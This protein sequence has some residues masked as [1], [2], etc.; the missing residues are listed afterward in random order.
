MNYRLAW[1]CAVFV[2]LAVGFYPRHISSSSN[3]VV[4]AVASQELNQENTDKELSDHKVYIVHPRMV[5]IESIES[6]EISDF[7]TIK[8]ADGKEVDV[9]L[10]SF[11]EENKRAL[12]LTA[13]ELVVDPKKEIPLWAKRES[14]RA[15]NDMVDVVI[16]LFEITSKE[17]KQKDLKFNNRDVIE[18][19]ADI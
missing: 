3:K 1:L 4:L 19:R 12:F 7:S 18:I 10:Y 11:D 9:L 14:A 16:M 5:A 17:D 15:M 6:W 2:L 13:R 8:D